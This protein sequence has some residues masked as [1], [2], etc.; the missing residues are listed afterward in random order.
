LGGSAV[1]DSILD[2]GSRHDKI[3]TPQQKGVVQMGRN[4]AEGLATDSGLSLK[5]QI[6]IHLVSNHYPPVPA[7]MADVCVEAIEAGNNEEWDREI[8]LPNG[9]Y[10]R[11]SLVAPAWAIIEQHHLESWLAESEVY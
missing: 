9:V 5:A 2:F 11:G 10:Y 6:E 8:Q 3:D 1:A 4:F 7:F